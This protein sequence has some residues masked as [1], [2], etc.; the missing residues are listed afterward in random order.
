MAKNICAGFLMS[1]SQLNFYIS[2]ASGRNEPGNS[3]LKA[4]LK[5]VAA[6]LL[7][8]SQR[9]YADYV[10]ADEA[11]TAEF[12]LIPQRRDGVPERPS[13]KECKSGG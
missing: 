8:A 4:K 5:T 6:K 10:Y 13:R 9:R 3:K 11:D 2:Q 7:W 1:D 12:A